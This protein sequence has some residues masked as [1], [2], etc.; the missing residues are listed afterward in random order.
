M[1]RA[2]F[3]LA[4]ADGHVSDAERRFM[5]IYLSRLQLTHEQRQ[6]LTADITQ[7]QDVASMFSKITGEKDAEDFFNFARLLVWCDGDFD[8]QEKRIMEML[9]KRQDTPLGTERLLLKLQNSGRRKSDWLKKARH[10]IS[11][12]KDV[13]EMFA[14][15]GDSDIRGGGSA[16]GRMS[17]SRFYMWRAVFAM[18]HADDVVTTEERK[19]LKGILSREPFTDE[20]RK[21]LEQDIEQAQDIAEMYLK[22][23]DQND[24]SQFFY[25]ARMLVWSDGD[26]GE[27]EQK[28]IMRL[29][30]NHVRTVDF[31]Q[32]IQDM[33]LS[34]DDDQKARI[35]KDHDRA[36]EDMPRGGFFS[37]LMRLLGGR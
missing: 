9:R 36:I 5:E 32:L 26:F 30:H 16:D 18:A 10:S 14:V 21:I 12:L 31:D 6:V 15:M 19:Y 3:A 29:K 2:V 25:H 27:Q 28:I 17:E 7:A 33:D 34:L 23:E 37:K 24:R 20:Q 1:W 13:F 35:V 8:E 22:I 4:H 11:G